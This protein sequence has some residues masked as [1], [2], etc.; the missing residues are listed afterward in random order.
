[1][2]G[3]DELPT[4][5]T[6]ISRRLDALR[7]G[8]RKA[9]VAFGISTVVLAVVFTAFAAA[10]ADYALHLPGAA[11]VVVGFLLLAGC[12]VVAWRYLWRSIAAD[13]P[14]RFIAQKIELH[15]PVL[16]ESLLSAV[17]FRRGV[18]AGESETLAR[19]VAQQAEALA[20][21]LTLE[22]CVDWKST[23][24]ALILAA[25]AVIAGGGFVLLRH[26]LATIAMHRYL[27][28]FSPLTWPKKVAIEPITIDLIAG[29]GES[30]RLQM[31]V[32]KGSD[33]DLRGW[34]ATENGDRLLMRRVS[35]NVYEHL[36]EGLRDSFSYHFEAGDDS[37]AD[38]PGRVEVRERPSLAAVDAHIAPPPYASTNEPRIVP[39]QTGAVNAVKGSSIR[40]EATTANPLRLGG[41]GSADAQIS[42]ENSTAPLNVVEGD[43]TRLE[44]EFVLTES[45]RFEIRLVDENG[46][47]NRDRYPYSIEAN[48]DQRPAVSIIEPQTELK[49]TRKATIDVKTLAEDDLGLAARWLEARLQNS[50]DHVQFP[51]SQKTE[52][53]NAAAEM[54]SAIDR[55]SWPVTALKPKVGDVIVY[56]AKA[57]DNFDPK[58]DIRKPGESRPQR[59]RIIDEVEFKAA[60]QRDALQLKKRIEEL[61]QDQQ[62]V[63]NDTETLRAEAD[64]ADLSSKQIRNS[65]TDLA[66]RQAR[67]AGRANSLAERFAE[68]TDRMARNQADDP[69]LS[70]QLENAT[71]GLRGSA[72]Q[73]M[74]PAADSIRRGGEQEKPT[75][76]DREIENALD[77][78]DDALE[79]LRRLLEEMEL[80]GDFDKL[81]R[82]LQ[83]LL[84][85]QQ[86]LRERV[87]EIAKETFGKSV[88][89]LD[90]D[91]RRELQEAERSQEELKADLEKE[92]R[93]MEQLAGSAR[94]SDS[95]ASESLRQAIESAKSRKVD[96]EMAS[97][98]AAISRNRMGA[99]QSAQRKAEEG[100][101][102]MADRLKQRQD[103]RLAELRKRLNEAERV[104]R[105]LIEDENRHIQDNRLARG[106]AN[107]PGQWDQLSS[108]QDRTRSNAR[109]LTGNL[110]K[111]QA[112]ASSGQVHQ[113]VEWMTRALVRLRASEGQKA[114]PHQQSA[115]EHLALA[116]QEL[117]K[118]R[119]ELSRR[120]S[121]RQL[122]MLQRDLEGLR[123]A[124]RE[125]N[126]RTVEMDTRR[127]EEQWSR[128]LAVLVAQLASRQT[129]L[130][131]RAS[132]VN[133]RMGQA[134]AFVHVMA[135]IVASM[136]NAGEKLADHRTDE[137]VRIEQRDAVRHI[138]ILIEAIKRDD[139]RRK[140]DQ[141]ASNPQQQRPRNGSQPPSRPQSVPPAAELRLIKLL[142][143]DLKKQ[144]ELAYDRTQQ[145]ANAG[146]E[147][148]NKLR[149][150]G[151]QQRE[152]LELTRKILSPQEDKDAANVDKPQERRAQ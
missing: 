144:I 18:A 105:R 29:M 34:L 94:Q 70:A 119:D 28:P 72:S 46:L 113:S 141:F 4:G 55:L 135:K 98:S 59:L 115:A 49:V 124:Q 128:G 143:T 75:D 111:M 14:D 134:Q 120:T 25:V 90:A 64:S 132:G 95:S 97:A 91:R 50:D 130:A 133:V 69:V 42:F 11:R 88:E 138:E 146:E 87:R 37:T 73:A 81:A 2:A 114:E 16:G 100:L 149:R 31:K 151:L 56:V 89:N 108:R 1:M 24:R 125:I 51:V 140:E 126:D 76:R 33:E 103:R 86:Q 36:I 45:T 106:A 101:A 39:L 79:S 43:P 84:M 47:E 117:E 129:G 22:R 52:T 30:L 150:L 85:R 123:D 137:T 82:D 71:T 19:A 78:Q 152:I 21:D 148:L 66:G 121:G 27:R 118:Y 23:H 139:N 80:S 116:L 92:L 107:A 61:I 6:E 102:E 41:V 68:V 65:T 53:E 142:Q 63:R 15:F 54:K 10:L 9:L 17:S 136:R 26:D 60:V 112:A 3:A 83:N 44:A 93:T 62:A 109:D 147:M 74:A 5:E 7:S 40:I 96:K 110:E 127:K 35:S 57:T 20:A 131:A 145:Q 48:E 99:A 58:G 122:E 32:V 13:L 38:R 8:A 67:L 104:L 77:R 12:V